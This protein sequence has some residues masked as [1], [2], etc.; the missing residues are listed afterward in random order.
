MDRNIST[1]LRK[2]G[3]A[4]VGRELAGVEG[5]RLHVGEEDGVEGL[6]G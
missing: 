2:R 6:A 1:Y 5:E 3:D 4:T